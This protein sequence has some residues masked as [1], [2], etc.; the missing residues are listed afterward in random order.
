MSLQSSTRKFQTSNKLQAPNPKFLGLMFDYF[1]VVG[2]WYL[3]FQAGK[4]NEA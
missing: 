1:L 2:F 3:N 4:P